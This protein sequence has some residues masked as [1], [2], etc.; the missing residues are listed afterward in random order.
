MLKPYAEPVLVR[1]GASLGA[2]LFGP[3]WLLLH[4]TWIPAALSLA[5]FALA[6]MLPL[7]VGAV[8][9]IGLAVLLGLSG[10]DLRRWGLERA[11]YVLIHVFA[12]RDRDEALLKLLAARP[13]VASWYRA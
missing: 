13:D 8:A 11:G 2:L 10:N 9:V 5:A 4:G 3:L 1:E 6:A 7:P 12:A